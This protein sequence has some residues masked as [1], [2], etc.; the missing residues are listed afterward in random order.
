MMPSYE[1]RRS[2]GKRIKWEFRAKKPSYYA[3]IWSNRASHIWAY[4]SEKSVK[5][6]YLEFSHYLFPFFFLSLSLLFLPPLLLNPPE[7]EKKVLGTQLSLTLCNPMDCS[8]PGSFVHEISQARILEWVAIPF[9][10]G[11]SQPRYRIRVSRVT[12]RFFTIWATREGP[13][14]SSLSWL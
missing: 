6:F 11:S 12:G 9:S 5:F 8:P 7:S 10:R 4:H 13:L 2:W 3:S 1:N 14:L